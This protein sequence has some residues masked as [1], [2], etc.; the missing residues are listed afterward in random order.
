VKYFQAI[1]EILSEIQDQESG[2]LESA[3]QT[4][5][6]SIGSGR[7]VLMF[8]AGHSAL[9]PQ[10]A[11]PRIGSLV[12]FVQITEPVLS[13]NGHVTGKGGQQQMSF[14]EQT[15]GL[16]ETILANYRITNQDTMLIISNSGINAVPVELCH[17]ANQKGLTTIGISSRAHSNC[18]QPKNPL[19]KRLLEIADIP[20]DTHIPEGDA[21]IQLANGENSGGGSTIVSM[22][23]LN[24]IVVR[25]AEILL[26]RNIPVTIYP[27]HNVSGDLDELHRKES[28]VFEKYKKLLSKF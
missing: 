7:G 11:F 18:N 23:I 24:G 10:E 14:L 5:A 13:Y 27:S 8:G 19:G 28:E 9:P 16:A 26:E 20:I 12:G 1:R 4:C 2:S 25:T 3:A 22:V 21:L 6:A 15:S 17:L